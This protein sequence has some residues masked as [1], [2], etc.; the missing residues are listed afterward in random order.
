MLEHTS[1]LFRAEQPGGAIGIILDLLPHSSVR[2]QLLLFL[3]SF[4]LLF[5][6]TALRLFIILTFIGRT[7]FHTTHHVYAS[8][9]SEECSESGAANAG[10][11]FIFA[12]R[13]FEV[14][15]VH[16]VDEQIVVN[17]V[18]DSIEVRLE[19]LDLV[20][21]PLLIVLDLQVLLRAQ[22]PLGLRPQPSFGRHEDLYASE[23]AYFVNV[24]FGQ[25]LREVNHHLKRLP[26]PLIIPEDLLLFA[27]FKHD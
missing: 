17:S 13:A 15:S 20:F 21:L 2:I 18:Y 27:V 25:H 24:L 1:H 7:T 4:F 22:Y 6:L 19:N 23:M 16:S 26:Q 11:K 9:G 12:D 5:I 10:Q 3:L 8:Q 14:L